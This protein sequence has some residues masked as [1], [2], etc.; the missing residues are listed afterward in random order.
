MET[1]SVS[2]G[3]TP[4][5]RISA[6]KG[7]IAPN[8]RLCLWIGPMAILGCLGMILIGFHE[9]DHPVLGYVFGTLFAHTTLAAAWM[10]FG[11]LPFI[12]R[13]PLSLGWLALDGC[14]FAAVIGMNVGPHEE[15]VFIVAACMLGQWVLVQLPLWGLAIGYGSRLCHLSQAER[16]GDPRALQFGIRQLMIVTAIVGVVL[17]IGRFVAVNLAPHFGMTGE[18]TIFIFLAVAAIGLTLPLLLAALLPRFAAPA[19]VLT[20][21]LIGLATAWER[22]LLDKFN[23]GPGPDVFHLIWINAIAAGWILFI[24]LFVRLNG[25]RLVATRTAVSQRTSPPSPT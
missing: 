21:V 15:V 2:K 9:P 11:P 5:R 13:L 6:E 8:V 1:R 14:C 4:T 12:W 20:L 25:F 23:S 16:L 18:W 10:A 3:T 19:V 7:S 24:A 22:P 17:G